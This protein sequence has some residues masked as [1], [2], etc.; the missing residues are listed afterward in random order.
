MKKS[1]IVLSAFL[2]GMF[3]A[4]SFVACSSDVEEK[5]VE[6]IVEV[7]VYADKS[8]K[9][10]DSL[11]FEG[12][13]YFVISNTISSG[14]TSSRAAN[15]ETAS[16]MFTTK[17][18]TGD[19]ELDEVIEKFA[20]DVYVRKLLKEIGITDY[21]EIFDPKQHDGESEEYTVDSSGNIYLQDTFLIISA[22]G[23]KLA[24]FK[25]AWDSYRMGKDVFKKNTSAE[26]V[27]EFKK[28]TKHELRTKYEPTKFVIETESGFYGSDLTKKILKEKNYYYDK[29][30]EVPLVRANLVNV[31]TYYAYKKLDNDTV[32]A[33]YA[34]SESYEDTDTNKG[35]FS[36]Y[37]YR[38]LKTTAGKLFY[39]IYKYEYKRGGY[40]LEVYARG[41]GMDAKDA[42][43]NANDRS[44]V[45]NIYAG[46]VNNSGKMDNVFQIFSELYGNKLAEYGETAKK[47]SIC[48]K[49][50]DYDANK[51]FL[52]Q[53]V[54]VKGDVSQANSTLGE[55]VKTYLSDYIRFDTEMK[56]WNGQDIPASIKAR[57]LFQKGA[58]HNKKYLDTKFVFDETASTGKDYPIFKEVN[59]KFDENDVNKN[60]FSAF[61]PENVKL[62]VDAFKSVSNGEYTEEPEDFEGNFLGGSIAKEDFEAGS[63]VDFSTLSFKDFPAG[64]L[65]IRNGDSSDNY[66]YKP[67]ASFDEYKTYRNEG[68]TS[69][70]YLHVTDF[71]SGNA[72][73]I[74]GAIAWAKSEA[75][76]KIEFNKIDNEY[77]DSVEKFIFGGASYGSTT[78]PKVGS[79][80]NSN[81]I[82]SYLKIHASGAGKVSAHVSKYLG[83]SD[84]DT[85]FVALVDSSGKVL[86]VEIISGTELSRIEKTIEA[87]ISSEQDVFLIF[88]KSTVVGTLD[89]FN[90]K[91][92]AD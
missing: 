88:R 23:K 65:A 13:D 52:E 92:I 8:T 21:I 24:T 63:S 89:V 34:Y 45:C 51:S 35:D 61:V 56:K 79:I 39:T 46:C 87:T 58:D 37:E 26:V 73:K 83:G 38:L 15:D 85:P 30:F 36:K 9:T 78:V 76:L 77:T 43:T 1:L 32:K 20:S 55:A 62:Y 31:N 71:V 59:D 42:T 50:S 4:S 67:I 48:I 90:M 80:V 68:G 91:F 25:Q 82:H 16:E 14:N 29:Y 47:V 28:L 10:G 84:N 44:N 49:S 7:P 40:R 22:D 5:I 27:E 12:V 18:N 11:K 75:K 72:Y 64:S 33:A 57:A 74:G 86:A 6:K 54:T 3:W 60:D 66:T 19:K 70:L 2:S 53:P 69:T 17:V 81:S 41:N